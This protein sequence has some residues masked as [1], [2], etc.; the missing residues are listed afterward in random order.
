MDEK[1]TCFGFEKKISNFTGRCPANGDI[2]FIAEWSDGYM[3]HPWSN[4][5]IQCHIS[6][7]KFG[8]IVFELW[9]RQ[10]APVVVHSKNYL[11]DAGVWHRAHV[12]SIVSYWCYSSTWS[13]TAMRFSTQITMI[14]ISGRSGKSNRNWGQSRSSLVGICRLRSEELDLSFINFHIPTQKCWIISFWDY[15]SL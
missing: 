2:F 15:C 7:Q 9:H 14:V 12:C 5:F 4:G 6:M 10:S 1:P 13:N 3:F 8:F 11:F